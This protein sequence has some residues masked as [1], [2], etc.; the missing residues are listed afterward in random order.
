MRI[1]LSDDRRA[2]VLAALKRH[3]DEEFDDPISDFRANGLLDLFLRELGPGVYNQG[4]RDACGYVQEKLA[5]I[6]GEIHEPEPPR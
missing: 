2:R 5:D 1:H 4:V 3:F 6:E